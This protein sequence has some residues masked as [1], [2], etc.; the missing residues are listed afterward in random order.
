MP[1]PNAGLVNTST[2]TGVME[3]VLGKLATQQSTNIAANDHIK[4]DTVVTSRGSSAVL[5][6]TTAYVT[7][8]GA[9]AVGRI[10]LKAGKTYKITAGVP[11]YLG[12]AATSTAVLR[13]YDATAGANLP[14]IGFSVWPSSDTTNEFGG[15]V[16]V[17]FFTP[18]QD[19]LI[20]L[21]IISAT[22]GTRYGNSASEEPWILVE[23][24]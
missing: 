3:F 4:F 14:G 6:T 2:A 17:A 10:T 20:E 5:D 19:S 21:R 13:L 12:S 1:F 18:T 9:A 7:T 15:A 23:T 11:F 22:T 16:A 8:Q 24:Y